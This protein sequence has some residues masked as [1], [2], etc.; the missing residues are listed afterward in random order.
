MLIQ[1]FGHIHFAHEYVH[2]VRD[3]LLTP[4]YTSEGYTL[5]IFGNI[6]CICMHVKGK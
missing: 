4:T 3:I 5:M 1:L 6:D 2:G